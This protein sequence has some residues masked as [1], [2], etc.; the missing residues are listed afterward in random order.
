MEPNWRRIRV[1][2]RSLDDPTRIAEK[3]LGPTPPDVYIL[4]LREHPFHGVQALRLI[5]E[6][7]QKALGRTGLLAHSFMLGQNGQSNGCVSFKNYDAF[8][9]AYL[10]DQIRRL[11]V[12]ASLN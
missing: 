8:L 3:N 5:P 7:E 2:A 6:D 12:V 9:R 11:V 10:N 4:E 1:S